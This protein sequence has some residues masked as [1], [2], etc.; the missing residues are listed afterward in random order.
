M[1]CITLSA[2]AALLFFACGKQEATITNQYEISGTMANADSSWIILQK[3]DNGAWIK[4]DSSQIIAGAFNISGGRV[5]M[6]ELHYLKVADNRNY[7]RLF[8]ENSNITFNGD[9]DSLDNVVISGSTI[10]AK[11]EA[12]QEGEKPFNDRISELYPKYDLADSLGDKEM[13]KELDEQYEA[14]SDEHKTYTMQVIAENSDNNLGPY[15]ATATFF[16]DEDAADL[17][18]VLAGFDST[19]NKSTYVQK[20]TK[21]ATTWK[22]VSVGQPSVNFTQNDSTGSPISLDSFKGQYVLIDFWA[23]W[24]GP[25]RQ[26]NPNVVRIYNDLHDKGFE[27]LGVSFDTS[28]EKWLKAITDDQLTWPHVSDLEGWSNAVGKLYGVRSIPHTVLI[29]KEGTILAKN[30]RGDELR[31]KLEELLL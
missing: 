19:L 10:H 30:I 26:E 23:S 31:E 4:I 20:L 5:D 29:D 6:P 11:Y 22:L 21:M 3:R 25:C 1:K 2:L 15:L 28:R 12:Y 24:C 13:E 7:T 18:Q 9:L 14:I 16:N 8:L 17:D 27:I